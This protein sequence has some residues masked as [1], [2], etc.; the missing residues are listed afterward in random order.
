[1]AHRTCAY[2]IGCIPFPESGATLNRK[3]SEKEKNLAVE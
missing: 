3:D 1:M 2:P